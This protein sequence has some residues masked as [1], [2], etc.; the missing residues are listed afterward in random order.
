MRPAA[1]AGGWEAADDDR[2]AL[3]HVCGHACAV[4]DVVAEPA[5]KASRNACDKPC[6]AAA[7]V[8]TLTRSGP[9]D[10]ENDRADPRD[11][12]I[13]GRHEGMSPLAD[14]LVG[15]LQRILPGGLLDDPDSTASSVDASNDR[16]GQTHRQWCRH[17][18]TPFESV[19][20]SS[21]LEN[22]LRARAAQLLSQLRGLRGIG[23]QHDDVASPIDRA[24]Q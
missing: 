5:R 18:V 4:T 21:D 20:A 24:V 12:A 22:A 6:S 17:E 23:M 11:H 9:Q 1:H 16:C 8:R 7:A 13:L 14:R 19:V 3:E 2:V 10:G 15:A